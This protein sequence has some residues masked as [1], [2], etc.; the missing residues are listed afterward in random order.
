MIGELLHRYG[1]K[2]EGV[3]RSIAAQEANVTKVKVEVH[4]H[5]DC[6]NLQQEMKIEKVNVKCDDNDRFDAVKFRDYCV[7]NARR[8]TSDI[9]LHLLSKKSAA[10][11]RT[12]RTIELTSFDNVFSPYIRPPP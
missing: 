2:G 10:Q 6:D 1:L 12:R 9:V 11:P 8:E 7:K 5:G 4:H 3:Q